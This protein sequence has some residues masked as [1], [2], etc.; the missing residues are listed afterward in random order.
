[1][2]RIRTDGTAAYK[3]GESNGCQR[4]HNY[5]VLRRAGFL[6]KHRENVRD[7]LASV[8]KD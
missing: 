3:R 1:M 2:P 7:G 8:F 4:M 5:V 6:V